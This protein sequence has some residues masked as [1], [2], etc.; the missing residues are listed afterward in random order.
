MFYVLRFFAFALCVVCLP[1]S[2][3]AQAE[4]TTPLDRF[5]QSV[6]L[7]VQDKSFDQMREFCGMIGIAEDGSFVASN[8]VRGTAHGC[9]PRDPENAARVVAS[10]HTHGGYEAD[11]ESEIP[12]V[13][14]VEGDMA[15][16]V[17]GYVSTPGGR[18]WRIDGS[19]GRSVQLCAPGCMPI[20]PDMPEGAD[21]D[22]PTRF[23]FK[24]LK[25]WYD[26]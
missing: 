25:R 22:I 23:S 24:R 6:L 2:G 5:A 11:M 19:T 14:D 18:F 4:P 20:D 7:S 21:S 17:F 1:L 9:L 3:Q 10:Y 13:Q 16:G 15:E 26:E 12:S 8:P